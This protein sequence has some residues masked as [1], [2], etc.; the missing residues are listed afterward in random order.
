MSGSISQARLAV[1]AVIDEIAKTVAAAAMR[2][3]VLSVEAE[4]MRVARRFPTAL[5]PLRDVEDAMLRAAAERNVLTQR[6]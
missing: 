4:A 2:R 5:I 1:Q 6:D 3:S